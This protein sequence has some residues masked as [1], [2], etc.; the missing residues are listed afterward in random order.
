MSDAGPRERD[1]ADELEYLCVEPFLKGVVE[2]RALAAAFE[3]G[4]IDHLIESQPSGAERLM[5]LCGA[6]A[7]GLRLLLGLLTANGVVERCDGGIRLSQPFMKALSYRDLLETK[8]AFADFALPDLTGLFTALIRDPDRFARDARILRLFRYD[9][10]FEA[11]PESYELAKRWMGI[12]T[13][14]TRYE[15]RA[16][17]MHHDFGRYRRMLDIGGNSG[18]F[19]LQIC[20]KHPNMRAVVFDLPVVCDLGREHVRAEPEAGRISF[21]R[22]NALADDLPDGCDLI[23]FKSMLHDWP[24]ERARQL[25]VRAGRVLAPGGTLLIFER[26]AVEPGGSATAYSAIPTLL[27]SRWFRSPALYAD[28]LADLGFRD[29]TVRNVELETAF[30]LVTARKGEPGAPPG[31]G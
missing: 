3:L 21:V 23:A 14:L 7:G 6:D 24:E 2:A 1:R 10:C 28:T 17:M 29:I 16:C 12:T 19:A 4:V 18:E 25:M 31:P 30:C 13:C 8:L 26:T 20:K 11:T 15:A 5:K 9:R 27:F 22:G